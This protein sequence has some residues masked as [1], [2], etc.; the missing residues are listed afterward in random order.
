MTKRDEKELNSIDIIEP[1]PGKVDVSTG[2]FHVVVQAVLHPDSMMDSVEARA[3]SDEWTALSR[4]G[5]TDNWSGDIGAPCSPSGQAFTLHARCKYVDPKGTSQEITDS[6]QNEG[7]C[8][9]KKR[10]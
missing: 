3:D 7:V 2:T 5:A 10:P 8:E 4:E 6:Q 1:L 9:S